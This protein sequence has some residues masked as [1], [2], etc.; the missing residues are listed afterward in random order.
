ML[1][2]TTTLFVSLVAEDATK[3]RTWSAKHEIG[4]KQDVGA[5]NDVLSMSE[6]THCGLLTPYGNNDLG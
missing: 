5:L 4:G 2:L 1:S 3:N 6:L